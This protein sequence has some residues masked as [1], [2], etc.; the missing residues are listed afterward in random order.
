VKIEN[1][2]ILKDTERLEKAIKEATNK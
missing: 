2:D 1:S